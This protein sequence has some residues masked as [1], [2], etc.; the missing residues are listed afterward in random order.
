MESGSMRN[1]L[2]EKNWI[3]LIGALSLAILPL[4][5][6]LSQSAGSMASK[7]T[8]HSIELAELSGN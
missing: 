6:G 5:V 1:A 7:N 8:N 2:V 4:L 3:N